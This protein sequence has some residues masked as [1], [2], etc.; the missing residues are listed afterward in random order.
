MQKFLK[1]CLI[2][3]TLFAVN[4]CNLYFITY[5]IKKHSVHPEHGNL[6]KVDFNYKSRI[7]C[8]PWDSC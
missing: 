5:Q 1:W 6:V 2:I 8:D 3:S 7:N 4:S